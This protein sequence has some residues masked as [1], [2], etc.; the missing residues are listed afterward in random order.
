MKRPSVIERPRTVSHDGLVPTTVV[1]QLVVPATRVSDSELVGATAPMS[2]ATVFEASAAASPA[3]SVEAEPNPPR[4]PE[5]DVVLPGEMVRRLVPSA[6]IWELTCCWAPSPSPTVRI[7]A[8][9]PIM[10]PST[11]SL[12]RSRWVTTRFES[13]PKRLDDVHRWA[14]S[15]GRPVS[16]SKIWPS[17][18]RMVRS[19]ASAT[20]DSWVIRTM[21]RPPTCR[22]SNRP[23][24]SSADDRVEVA[25]RLVGQDERRVGDQGPGHRDPLLLTAG[26]LAGPVLDPVGEAD[27]VEGGEGPFLADGSFDAGVDERELDVAPGVE[28]EARRLNCWKTK[29]IRRFRTWARSS[30]DMALTSSPASR[31]VPEVGTSRQPRMC[32]RVDLPEPD[33][34]MTATYSPASMVKETPRSASTSSDPVPVGLP[35]IL[36][37]R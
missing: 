36:A 28:S 23:S 9:I 2:G 30:S 8:A 24:T 32:M 16:A 29:P 18:I 14:G 10:M 34:P 13:G 35:D 33:G 22:S 5:L 6:A 37:R 20:S 21:V 1:V 25:G 15:A 4:M 12:D 3:V 17:L 11:V 26:E 7:T 19:A 31:N 27:P